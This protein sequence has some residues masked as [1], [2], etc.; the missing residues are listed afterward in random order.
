MATAEIFVV[1]LRVSECAL[2][3]VRWGVRL[4]GRHHLRRRVAVGCATH[5]RWCG[6][7]LQV[8]VPRARGTTQGI[9]EA[10]E[11]VDRVRVALR[12]AHELRRGLES[13]GGLAHLPS[14]DARGVA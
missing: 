1:S 4:L 11:V 3:G 10:Q 12:H 7:A 14:V 8:V 9:L 13:L 6:C 2:A 5:A